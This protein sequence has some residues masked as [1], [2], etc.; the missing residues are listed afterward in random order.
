[1][2]ACLGAMGIIHG[3]LDLEMIRDIDEGIRTANQCFSQAGAVK[4]AG[5]D[6]EVSYA[7]EVLLEKYQI[8]D[9]RA[10]LALDTMLMTILMEILGL[11]GISSNNLEGVVITGSMGSLREPYDFYGRLTEGLKNTAAGVL[12]P[13]TSGSMGS[14]QIAR[15][16]FLGAQEILGIKVGQF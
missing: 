5:L 14:A 13:P 6:E 11:N 10:K 7:R 12:L 1:M 15:D 8:G 3:P 9:S 2:D 16:V 4:V